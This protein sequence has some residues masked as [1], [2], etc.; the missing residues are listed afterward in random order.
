MKIKIIFFLSILFCQQHIWAEEIS[1]EQIKFEKD[2]L[3][4]QKYVPK[5]YAFFEAV[6]GDLNKDGKNDLVL[7]VKATDPNAWVVN[8]FDERVD[9]NRRGMIVFLNANGKYQKLT[10]NLTIF[11]SE[12]EDGGVYFAPELWFEIKKNVLHTT[13]SHGRYGYWKY[14]FRVQEND[15]RLIGYDSADHH[16]PYVQNETSINLITGKVLDRENMNKDY[17]DDKPRFKESWKS[18]N[19]PAIFLSNIPDIDELRLGE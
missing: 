16:G 10:Q 18:R 6:E 13:Y 11:S 1:T 17:D 7:I 12:N 14:T 5:N 9:R 3:K 4:F 8:R 15:L 19:Y 2:K